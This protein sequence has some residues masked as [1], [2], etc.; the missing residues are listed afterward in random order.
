MV[1]GLLPRGLDEMSY[2]LAMAVEE[3]GTPIEACFWKKEE[4]G[5]W[6][7]YLAA[8]AV[9][10]SGPTPVLETVQ[11]EFR[12]TGY[13]KGLFDMDDVCAIGM[14]H[15]DLLALRLTDYALR[16]KG[17]AF[18]GTRLILW[19]HRTPPEPILVAPLTNEKESESDFRLMIAPTAIRMLSLSVGGPDGGFVWKGWSEFPALGDWLS[20]GEGSI[21]T[22]ERNV[23][24]LAFENDRIAVGWQRGLGKGYLPRDAVLGALSA[25][26][27]SNQ[28]A[29]DQLRAPRAAS[30]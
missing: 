3:A 22:Y 19:A 6:L 13:S 24:V 20:V 23:V 1:K 16:G 12:R 2:K 11:E 15:E 4:S 10:A 5:R 17:I 27:R 7:F 18:T 26:V 8:P 28:A 25:Y 29:L 21:G 9:D 14:N 30:A